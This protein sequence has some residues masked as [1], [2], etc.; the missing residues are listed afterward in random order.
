LQI[1]GNGTCIFE[2]QDTFQRNLGTLSRLGRKVSGGLGGKWV[3]LMFKNQAI[4]LKG[5]YENKN[6]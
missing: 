5:N 2:K 3:N 1:E 4:N 6:N